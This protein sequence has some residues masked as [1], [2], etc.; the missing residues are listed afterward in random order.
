ML[1]RYATAVTSGS[2]ITVALLWAMQTLIHLHPGAESE[3]RDRYDLDWVYAPRPVDPVEPYEPEFDIEDLTTIL[4]TPPS[5]A[6]GSGDPGI[7]V[8]VP[9]PGPGTV[10]TGPVTLGMPDNPLIT[11]VRVEPGYPPVAE[12]RGLEGWVD[13]R[14]DVTASG[15]VTNVVVI[16]SSHSIFERAAVKAA[17]RF[18]YKAP[19]IDG[20]AQ[21]ATGINYRFRFNMEG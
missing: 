4:P 7:P 17:E 16:A 18:R 12:Q 14:F 9:T 3:P 15:L 6:P 11:I 2:L 10:T 20:V 13:V 1:T 5:S 8:A 21:P 19:V